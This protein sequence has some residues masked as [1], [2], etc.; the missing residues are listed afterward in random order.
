MKKEE[1]V[2]CSQRNDQKKTTVQQQYPDEPWLWKKE[3]REGVIHSRSKMTV[4][5][6]SLLALFWNAISTFLMFKIF[7]AA[8]K[9]NTAALLGL[10]FSIIGV[11]LII[12]SIY[13]FLRW[14]KFGDPTFH[15]ASVPGVLGG[16]L[17]GTLRIPTLLRPEKEMVIT[18][19]CVHIETDY[20]GK[21]RETTQTI[22]GKPKNCFLVTCCFKKITAPVYPLIFISPMISLRW[23]IARKIA[24]LSGNFV[25]RRPCRG[26]TFQHPLIFRYSGHRKA[27][28][29]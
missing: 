27:I 4:I 6:S 20:N 2:F 25:Q 28:Q 21:N 15:M 11:L 22:L 14:R 10:V 23:M 26:W 7:D 1:F 8:E 29:T 9:G 24:R 3:W 5:F 16:R 13:L 19:D 18:L 17:R 12:V